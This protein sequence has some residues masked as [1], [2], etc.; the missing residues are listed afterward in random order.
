MASVDEIGY[1]RESRRLIKLSIFV[2]DTV[3]DE[4]FVASTHSFSQTMSAPARYSGIPTVLYC[5]VGFT[6]IT[7]TLC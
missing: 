6:D 2:L 3:I 5:S 4:V 1:L 7:S